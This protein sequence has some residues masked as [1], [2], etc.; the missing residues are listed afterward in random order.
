MEDQALP[1]G[2]TVIRDK[3]VNWC[4]IHRDHLGRETILQQRKRITSLKEDIR[5]AG[6]ALEQGARDLARELSEVSR[7]KRENEQLRERLR[8]IADIAPADWE[9]DPDAD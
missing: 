8:L 4:E 1:C 3:V 6:D 7:L 9:M 2:C 5:R